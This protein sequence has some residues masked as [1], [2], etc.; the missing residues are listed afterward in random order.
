[1]RKFA[2]RGMI[3]L[4]AILSAALLMTGCGQ[5]AAVEE[6]AAPAAK[7]LTVG[8]DL[9]LTGPGAKAGTEFKDAVTMAFEGVGNKIGDYEVK[10]VWID[11][12]SDPQKG[13]AAYEQAVV[14]D[15]IDV[16][17]LN[18]NSSVAIALMETVSKYQ[19]P[20]FFGMGAAGTINEKWLSNDKYHYWINKGWAMPDKMTQ[21]YVD[22]ITQTIEK[23]TWTPRNKKIAIYGDDT[24]WGRSYG[25]S[26]KKR[27]TEAGW[28]VVSEEYTKLGE[29]DMYPLLTKMKSLDVSLIAGTISSPPSIAAFIKQAREVDLKALMI[30]DALGET[31]DFYTL[32]GEASDYILDNRPIF[33]TEKAKQFAADFK[34]KFGYEPSAAAAGQVYDYTRFFIQVANATLTEYGSLDKANL[35]KYAQEK[36][37]TG[38]TSFKDGVLMDEYIYTA[39]SAPDPVVGEGK[40]IFP[41]VQYFGGKPTVIWPDSQKTADVKIPDYAK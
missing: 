40:Y 16:G 20:H 13:T 8:V 30:C 9:P 25:A 36:L 5:K 11:D 27:F 14:K 28:E 7:V 38:Q 26:M 22:T 31:A 39:D 17:I 18:W 24:D 37:M 15:K 35:Y 4:A 21:A 3:F 32:T 10:L 33:A 41:I 12:Q 1:M 19:I 29:T 23:G 34:T 6:T 2:T